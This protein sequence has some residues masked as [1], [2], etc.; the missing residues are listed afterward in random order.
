MR[1]FVFQSA[2]ERRGAKSWMLQV[3]NQ[4]ESLTQIESNNPIGYILPHGGPFPVL[5]LEEAE[6]I[7]FF[8]SGIHLGSQ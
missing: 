4:E 7:R 2:L 5:S 8:L 6:K 1:V 3:K